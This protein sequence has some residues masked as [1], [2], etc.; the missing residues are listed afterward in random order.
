MN[1]QIDNLL[2]DLSDKLKDTLSLFEKILNINQKHLQKKEIELF[3]KIS[4]DI[5]NVNERVNDFYYCLLDKSDEEKSAEDII[6]LRE[7][8]INNKVH[9]ILLPYMLYIKIIL[10]NKNN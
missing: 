1:V 10:K 2:E 9:D 5:N 3:S 6:S 7:R 8:E 4:T